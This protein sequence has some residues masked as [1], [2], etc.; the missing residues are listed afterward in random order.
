MGRYVFPKFAFEFSSIVRCQKIDDHH[1]ILLSSSSGSS[2]AHSYYDDYLVTP[3]V[4]VIMWI[5]A[6][7]KTKLK[8][9]GFIFNYTF[10]LHEIV[11][12]I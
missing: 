3:K 6:I 2:F 1:I 11:P 7:D 12:L 10:C 4:W 5:D 8:T 9:I